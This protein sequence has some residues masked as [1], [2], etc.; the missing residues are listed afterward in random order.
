MSVYLIPIPGLVDGVSGSALPALAKRT[1]DDIVLHQVVRWMDE[2]VH[3]HCCGKIEDNR[4]RFLPPRL[5]EVQDDRIRLIDSTSHLERTTPYATLSYRWGPPPHHLT[6]NEQTYPNLLKGINKRDLPKTFQDATE[7]TRQLRIH[8]L[9]IDSVCIIQSGKDHLKD[10]LNHVKLMDSIYMNG[11]INISAPDSENADQGM[12]YD[13]DGLPFVP[14]LRHIF[15]SWPDSKLCLDV[16]YWI[17]DYNYAWLRLTGKFPL[18]SRG[19]VFQERL[20]APRTVLFGKDQVY[21]ECTDHPSAICELMPTFEHT[22]RYEGLNAMMYINSAK[23]WR[24]DASS[25]QPWY[26]NVT[27]YSQTALTQPGDKLPAIAGVAKRFCLQD[28]QYFAGIFK[29]A[30]PWALLWKPVSDVRR[31][32][33]AY[34]APTWSWAA[35]E[36][37]VTHTFLRFAAAESKQPAGKILTTAGDVSVTY[38]NPDDTF[39]QVKS[40]ELELHGPTLTASWSTP[41]TKGFQGTPKEYQLRIPPS[42][43]SF[44]EKPG[45]PSHETQTVL[46]QQE[47]FAGASLML[48]V[49]A[50]Q[51]EYSEAAILMILEEPLTDHNRVPIGFRSYGLLL[52]PSKDQANKWIRI[53]TFLIS[54]SGTD[55]YEKLQNVGLRSH[56]FAII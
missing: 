55:G 15:S 34:R 20:L 56:S 47:Y 52:V 8:Y 41:R 21:W 18:D 45:L 7:V 44:L 19:W 9:W 25:N 35:Y 1:G 29:S 50:E 13:R 3:D 10:W 36:G 28:D 4:S 42:D 22:P 17:C 40:A 16:P 53:G 31:A 48:D 32:T 33:G 24:S 39:G 51:Y 37:S 27:R 49:V 11:A 38:V 46:P 23:S 30:L 43:Y 5:L 6:L 2:C 12:F 14:P 26:Q 54:Y